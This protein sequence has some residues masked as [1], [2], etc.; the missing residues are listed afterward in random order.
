MIYELREYAPAPVSCPPSTSGSK[1]TPS[2]CSRST[3]W[4]WSASG[5]RRSVTLAP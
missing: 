1:T 3:A 4:A 5:L 2:S